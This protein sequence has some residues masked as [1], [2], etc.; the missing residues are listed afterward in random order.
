MDALNLETSMV[1]LVSNGKA[2]WVHESARY[3]YAQSKPYD[4]VDEAVWAMFDGKVEWWERPS[5]DDLTKD[6][7]QCGGTGKCLSALAIRAGLR[8]P[9]ECFTCSGTGKVRRVQP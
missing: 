1:L 6:C 3:G 2:K 9:Y 5:P 8:E 4:T 7:P